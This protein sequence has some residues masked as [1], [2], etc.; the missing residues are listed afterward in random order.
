MLGT[1]FRTRKIIPSVIFPYSSK[2]LI[3]LD[4]RKKPY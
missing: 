1:M 2:F 4:L 3:M